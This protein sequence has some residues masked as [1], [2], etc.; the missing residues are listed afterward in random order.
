MKPTKPEEL[1]PWGVALEQ[2]R[3]SRG[4]SKG[5][6]CRDARIERPEYRVICYKQVKGPSLETLERL[7]CALGCTWTEWGAIYDSVTA[8]AGVLPVKRMPVKEVPSTVWGMA[9]ERL[10][11]QKY[12]TITEVCQL[13]KIEDN[14]YHE[15]CYKLKDWP[16][17][18]TISRLLASLGL[19]WEEWGQM[20]DAVSVE[21]THNKNPVK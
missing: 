3:E 16:S 10:R 14:K 19:T 6:L 21:A 20:L 5:D 4:I 17:G 2:L 18:E 8:S 1:K 11:E 7:L 13:A 12:L 15:I 9:L